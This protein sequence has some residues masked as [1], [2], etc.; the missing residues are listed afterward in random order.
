MNKPLKKI[1][2]STLC[3]T[4]TATACY[5][6]ITLADRNN[7]IVT[8]NVCDDEKFLLGGKE[9]KDLAPSFVEL[10]K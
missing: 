4:S 3:L 6:I 8:K 2:L 9:E 5:G 1:L 10:T 7:Q